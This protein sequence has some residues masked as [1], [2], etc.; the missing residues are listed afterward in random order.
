MHPLDNKAKLKTML[1]TNM[2]G[3]LAVSK[4][5]IRALELG[6]IPS[7]PLYDSRYDLIVDTKKKLI[8]AQIKYGGGVASNS[9]GNAVVKLDY[10]T[11]NRKVYTYNKLEVDALI[12]YLP[13]VDKLCFFPKKIFIGKRKICIRILEPKNNQAKRIIAARDYYW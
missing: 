9:S 4:A 8:R 2:K 1:T 13:Q 3:Q 10:E 7:R 5:E 11:R 6:Y 12:V